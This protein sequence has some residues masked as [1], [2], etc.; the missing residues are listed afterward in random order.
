MNYTLLK[1]YNRTAVFEIQGNAPYYAEAPFDVYLDDKLVLREENRNIF[2][3]SE[4]APDTAYRVSIGGVELSFRTAKESFL[5]NIR[6]FG[7]KGDGISDDTIF[8]Q[9][10]ILSCSKGGT[11]LVPEGTYKCTSIFLK[12]DITLYLKEKSRIMGISDRNRYPILPEAMMSTDGE[13]E[14]I[15]GTWEGNPLGSFAALITGLQVENVSIIGEGVLDGDAGSGDW[16]TDAKRKNITWRPRMIFLNGCQNIDIQGIRVENSY[17]WTIHPYYT[18]NLR[19]YDI[20]IY[21]PYNSPNTD[22]INP[23]SS[24]DVEIAG[25][26][27]SVGDDCISLKSG[28]YYMAKN[29]YR[30]TK[31]V[32]VRNCLMKKGHG[33]V[34][35]GSEV[36][37]GIEHIT[38]RKC[39]MH[40]T[41]KGLRIKTRRGRG[42]T[43]FLS[44]IELTDCIL[45]DVKVPFSINMFYFCDPDGHSEYVWSKERQSV[46]ELTPRVGR[47]SIRDVRCE[48]ATIASTFFYGLPE[49]PIG[50]IEMENVTIE[51][52][53]ALHEEQ[54][55]MLDHYPP[56]A[57]MGIFA[58]NIR[59]L[60]LKNVQVSGYEGERLVL[61]DI[62]AFEED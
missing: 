58:K 42:K 27:I 14:A 40:N 37:S 4:L 43:S 13:S 35:I 61:E 3:L 36:A 47:I 20:S 8:I 60:H 53:R 32:E 19:I 9:A 55:A 21:N 50:E 54:P 16:W 26:R 5:L 10:A 38:I 62:G 52:G 6:D 24:Q 12:S 31:N 39:L 22:G 46:D 25:V 30:Q 2:S 59:K 17:S 23:E 51:M 18:I 56:V 45:R 41:D 34:V 1:A 49:E 29:H 11:V 48:N 7:A 15:F 33:G 57:H 44:D 28:K